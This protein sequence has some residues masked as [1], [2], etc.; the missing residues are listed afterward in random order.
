[1]RTRRLWL[2]LP[3][4]T[5]LF[6]PEHLSAQQDSQQS[7]DVPLV[8]A[9]F[10][11]Q[12]RESNQML[13]DLHSEDLVVHVR[14][15]EGIV[16]SMKLDGG[17]K[18]VALILDPSR[19]VP[20]EEWI[21]EAE[22]A[23]RMVEI[24]R[25]DDRFLLFLEG[26]DGPQ[27]QLLTPEETDRQLRSLTF[28][29][30]STS[31]ST[32]RVYDTLFNAVQRLDPPA[33]GDALILFGHTE[34]AGS[35]A[36]PDQLLKLI[37]RNRQR[38]LGFSFRDPLGD[39]K[40]DQMSRETGYFVSFHQVEALKGP[41]QMTLLDGF[42]SDVYSWIAQPYRLRIRPVPA[43]ETASLHIEVQN[44]KARVPRADTSYYPHTIYPCPESGSTMQ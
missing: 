8:V 18:R 29:R 44:P 17:P 35:K 32:G 31:D 7:C 15:D 2:A 16:E 20:D 1:M 14:S 13:L 6:W 42:M 40:I 41:L 25:P 34:D 9:G 38:L 5:F 30:P 22:M 11:T 4:A 10:N 12:T 19:N 26:I 36:D 3:V 24:A 39:P 43:K 23:A 33:F 28:A 37:L 27:E 21:L